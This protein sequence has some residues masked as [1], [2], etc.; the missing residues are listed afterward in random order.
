M[1]LLF[2][3]NVPTQTSKTVQTTYTTY[4]YIY[5]SNQRSLAVNYSPA[6]AIYGSATGGGATITPSSTQKTDTTTSTSQGSSTTQGQTMGG[7]EWWQLLLFGG[8]ALVGVWIIF[9][10]VKK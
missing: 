6:V 5:T 1:G 4:K 9:R 8:L 7:M 2:D 10:R 3:I